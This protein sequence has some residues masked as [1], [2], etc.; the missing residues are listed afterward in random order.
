MGPYPVIK[1]D[2]DNLGIVWHSNKPRQ[3]LSTT[4]PQADVFK[5]LEQYIASQPFALKF[6]YVALH[7]DNTKSWK[8]CSLKERINIKVNLLAKKSLMCTHAEDKYFNGHF[9][10]EDFQM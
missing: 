1:E 5:I 2:C 3:P 7:A 10:L 6:L 8:D 9:C 4:Q